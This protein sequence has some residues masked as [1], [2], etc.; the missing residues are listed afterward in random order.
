MTDE[1]RVIHRDQHGLGQKDQ[2]GGRCI[3]YEIGQ[4]GMEVQ[5]TNYMRK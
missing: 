2:Q 4:K 3:K 5:N 1:N